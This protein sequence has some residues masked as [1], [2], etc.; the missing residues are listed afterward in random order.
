MTTAL[1]AKVAGLTPAEESQTLIMELAKT[2][3]WGFIELGGLLCDNQDKAY[4][5][6]TGH[7]SFKDFVETIG[8]G[9]YT[10]VT[11]LMDIS[12]MVAKGIVTREQV[13]EI[14]VAKTVLL[15]PRAKKGQLTPE[16]IE[17]AKSCTWRELR[18]ELGGGSE[19]LPAPEQFIRCPRCG[20]EFVFHD[21][22]LR[23]RE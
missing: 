4:W 8:I 15:L 12:R 14:G 10:W 22:M 23:G 5:S 2:V 17:L 18:E 20:Q 9:D 13:L 3:K 6:R 21:D 7:E 19:A 11:R 16:L 1:E